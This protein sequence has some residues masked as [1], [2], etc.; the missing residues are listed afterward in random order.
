MFV[1]FVVLILTVRMY[2][3]KI[4]QKKDL[5][6]I[7]G[8]D[9]KYH[10][11]PYIVRLEK[12]VAVSV[13]G[14]DKRFL[15]LII[16]IHSCSCTVLTSNWTLTAAHCIPSELQPAP[17]LFVRYGTDNPSDAN[18]TVV[19]VLAYRKHPSYR[20]YDVGIMPLKIENDV[21]ILNTEPI[22][23]PLYGKLSAID[24][25][26]LFGQEAIACGYGLTNDTNKDGV[27]VIANTLRL[28]KPLQVLDVMMMR[29]T[30]KFTYSVVY[31]GLCM[32][33]KCG[34]T[35]SMC[36]GDSGGP[37]LHKSGVV[38]VLSLGGAFDCNLYGKSSNIVGV[39]TAISPFIEW[40]G[41]II[42]K[43]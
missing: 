28:N 39:I 42:N 34:N 24:Y 29:C 30:S 1:K 21:A 32:A 26:S 31:P 20:L 41:S 23:L 6:V 9:G 35:V 14:P 33:R 22:I 10:R 18:A 7:G 43:Q 4:A 36:P 17:L 27:A 5:R 13:R 38:G 12:K 19:K 3:S 11:Y 2:Y 40:I 8:K 15:T 25:S 16:P 37:L